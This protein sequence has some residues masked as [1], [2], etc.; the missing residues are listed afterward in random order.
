MDAIYS[1]AMKIVHDRLRKL[2]QSLHIA[3]IP[4]AKFNA[5]LRISRRYACSKSSFGVYQVEIPESGIKY[6]VNLAEKICEC[7]DFYQY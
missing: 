4:I 3:D 6:I 7:K 5:R 2:Q 1:K